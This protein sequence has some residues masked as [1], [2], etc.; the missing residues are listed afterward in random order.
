METKTWD[1]E[2]ME[3]KLK[4]DEKKIV[5]KASIIYDDN[6]YAQNNNFC[7]FN[8]LAGLMSCSLDYSERSVLKMDTVEGLRDKLKNDLDVSMLSS[9]E[10]RI[11]NITFQHP[12]EK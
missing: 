8:G 6:Y 1:V 10:R 4:E 5:E 12:M 9:L 11:S 2:D 3:K 7:A